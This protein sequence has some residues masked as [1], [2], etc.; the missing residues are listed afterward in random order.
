MTAR[1]SDVIVWET[2]DLTAY[3]RLVDRLRETEF[4]GRYFEV[5]DIIPAVENDYAAS[6][7]R[8]PISG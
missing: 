3:R 1:V 5:L 2:T 4:W 8:A 7:N 6:Y